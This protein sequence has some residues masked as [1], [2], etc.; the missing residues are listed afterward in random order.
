MADN[1]LASWQPFL[2]EVQGRVHEVF[3][4]ETPFLAE[5]SGVGDSNR[6][7]RVTRDMDGNRGIFSGKQVRHT[8]VL[9]QL[10]GAGFVQEASTW[11]VP[12]ALSSDEVVINLVRALV[13][14]SVTVDVERD[15]FDN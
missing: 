11:N 7:G 10:P 9:A 15:S 1:T 3:P 5:M 6:V 8:V 12:H 2:F 13:P 4:T 14:F